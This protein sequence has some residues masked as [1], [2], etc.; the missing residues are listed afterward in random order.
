MKQVIEINE[1]S[2]FKL[3]PGSKKSFFVGSLNGENQ[4]IML[5]DAVLASLKQKKKA[6]DAA[7]FILNNCQIQ[8]SEFGKMLCLSPQLGK[9]FLTFSGTLRK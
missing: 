4:Q 7:K 3:K 8:I 1:V 5:S 6:E 9:A 2:N